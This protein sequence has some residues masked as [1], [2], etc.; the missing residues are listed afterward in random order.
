MTDLV[1]RM[2]KVVV[3]KEQ[4][5]AGYPAMPLLIPQAGGSGKR[6]SPPPPK[7]GKSTGGTEHRTRSPRK[8][9]SKSMVASGRG[10]R[11][12]NDDD[13]E[14]D[15]KRRKTRRLPGE[16]DTPADGEPEKR[17]PPKPKSHRSGD[18]A[19]ASTSG[20]TSCGARPPP[21]SAA[22]QED[23]D[24]SVSEE[25]IETRKARVNRYVAQ[26]QI[27]GEVDDRRAEI[28]YLAKRDAMYKVADGQYFLVPAT[29]TYDPVP[30]DLWEEIP[31]NA[32]A[33]DKRVMGRA[34]SS[35]PR[36]ESETGS[37]VS[38][39]S[40]KSKRSAASSKSSPRDPKQC[41]TR[42][43]RRIDHQKRKLYHTSQP[44]IDTKN[45]WKSKCGA[46]CCEPVKRK[47]RST[48]TYSRHLTSCGS[49]RRT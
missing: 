7:K 15:K 31:E 37:H 27:L 45:R 10:Y 9:G 44:D 17:P 30:R 49:T 19:G 2:L 26:H 28:A 16:R 3:T 39:K 47:N 35:T 12:G 20:D 14:D 48:I 4:I 1:Q 5:A 42:S 21:A 24:D 25:E 13:D 11:G 38:R 22:H 46:T 40:A 33:K 32:A 43:Q 34:S 29:K 41:T 8:G 6:H 18:I 23:F 36:R